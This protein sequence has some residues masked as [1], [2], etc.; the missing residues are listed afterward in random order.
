MNFLL[1]GLGGALGAIARYGISTLLPN[2][3]PSRHFPVATLLAN[4]VGSLLIGFVIAAFFIG[5]RL[6]DEWRLLMIVGVLGGFTTLS[7]FSLET[8]QLVQAGRL[9]V[10]A[11]YAILSLVGMPVLCA[12]GWWIGRSV[13]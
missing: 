1:V 5:A 4:A 9:G 8:M 11:M 3:D 7:A 13:S 2:F 12:I 6:G 10:A